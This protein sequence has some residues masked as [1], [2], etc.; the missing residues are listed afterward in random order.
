MVLK[1]DYSDLDTTDLV[2][3]GTMSGSAASTW[4]DLPYG[5]TYRAAHAVCNENLLSDILFSSV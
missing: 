5:P 2:L 1:A 3:T 4:V